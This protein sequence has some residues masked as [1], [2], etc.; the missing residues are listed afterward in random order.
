MKR[1]IVSSIKFGSGKV[2]FTVIEQLSTSKVE[3]FNSCSPISKV[4]SFLE[5]SIKEV[6][7][8]IG[9]KL[10]DAFIVIEPTESSKA[11][12]IPY[13]Q[14]LVIAGSNVS[15]KDIENAIALTKKKFHSENNKVI[16]VQPILFSVFDVMEKSYSKAPIGKKGLKLV[17]T[18]M[19]TTISQET[20]DYV[21]QVVKSKGLNIKQLLLSTQA[22][23]QNNLSSSAL[24]EGAILIHIGQNQSFITINKNLSTIKSMSFYDF[25]YRNLVSGIAK[26]F[27]C[28]KDEA[29][30]LI[31][32]HGS[33]NKTNINRVILSNKNHDK[34]K[35]VYRSQL[36]E[37]IESFIQK[38]LLVAN[39][40]AF[41]N[42]VSHLPIVLSG[43]IS[44]IDGLLE[45]AKEKFKTKHVS[46]YNPTTYIEVNGHNIEAIGTVNF[47]NRID[48][49]LGRQLDTTVETNPN[50]VSSMKNN[51]TWIS[52]VLEK[53][54]GKNV[55][56]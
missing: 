10:T 30:N 19:V 54:G 16:L 38:L 55:W 15:K 25:G 21:F 12:I 39:Q 3:I 47:I 53:I 37:I 35:V 20:Y 41:Q 7:T 52:R 14:E 9:G 32:I 45:F 4:S 43:H 1:N 46:I 51:N 40:F 8:R 17:M 56:K 31:A 13:K 6:E 42:K 50:T 5:K 29:R 44:K 48:E 24:A 23:S 26:I 34:N 33:L 27:N 28:S 18:S 36:N 22:I 49:I 11:K 2:T